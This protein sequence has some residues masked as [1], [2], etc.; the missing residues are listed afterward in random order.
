MVRLLADLLALCLVACS[1]GPP[2]SVS[3]SLPN[4][5]IGRR[6]ARHV[7]QCTDAVGIRGVAW[8]NRDA[9]WASC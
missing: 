4:H 9:R 2:L 8:R 6:G 3:N 5:L 1:S 7:G